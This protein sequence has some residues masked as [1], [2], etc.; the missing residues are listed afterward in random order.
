VVV[1][2]RSNGRTVTSERAVV[3]TEWGEVWDLG[4]PTGTKVDKKHY[5]VDLHNIVPKGQVGI[6]GSP[7]NPTPF[8][9][10]R[11]K[12][13]IPLTFPADFDIMNYKV[14]T[15]QARFF[16]KDGTPWIQNW[17]QG[18]LYFNQGGVQQVGYYNLTN[19]NGTL[20]LAGDSKEPQGADLLV[21]PDEVV[22]AP[23]GEKPVDLKPPFEDDGVT[24]VNTN[25]A[26]G[27]FCA[28]IELVEL[29]FEGPKRER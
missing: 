16:F 27:W 23:A 6:H 25:D 18:D 2:D 21:T 7:L 26:Q 24:P 1:T 10:K 17:T 5:I 12:Y 29:R 14:C 22:I 28:Y 3:V 13:A 15:A 9:F 19:N 4:R 20:G 11:E 8:T